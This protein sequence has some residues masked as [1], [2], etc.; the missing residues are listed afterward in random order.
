MSSWQASRNVSSTHSVWYVSAMERLVGVLHELS[1]A[2]DLHAIA[3]IVRHA[4]RELTGADGATFILRENEN[5]YYLDEDAISPLWKGMKFPTKTCISGWV[6]DHAQPVVIDNIYKDARIPQD[7]YRPTF[8]KS[9]AM[10]PIRRAAPIGA[11]GNYWAKHHTPSDEVI[12]VLQALADTT[13]VALE[14]ASLYEQLQAQLKNL[15]ESNYELSRFAWVASHDLEEPLRNIATQLLILQKDYG[16]RLDP[17]GMECVEQ[18]ANEAIRLQQ[19]TDELMIHA[20]AE[21]LENFRPIGLDALV[22][23]VLV[24]MAGDVSRSRAVIHR[25]PLPWIWGDPLLVERLLQN[26]IS[27]ALKFTKPNQPPRIT[28][29]SMQQGELWRITIRDEGIGIQKENL[30]RI[31]SMFHRLH[32]QEDYPGSGLGLATCKKI[33]ALHGGTIWMESRFGKGSTVNFTLPVPQSMQS[34]L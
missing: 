1:Q 10:V 29:S 34:I 27:N 31:F 12:A 19:V 32:T 7:A 20:H 18:A 8:V 33:V 4:A 9:L 6:M 21:K 14:N 2:R 13:S 22:D 28:I 15:K 30:E 24:E 26:L 16:N 11:I 5:C 17:R 23:R 3:A 25:D